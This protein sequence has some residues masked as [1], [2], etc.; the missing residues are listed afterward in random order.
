VSLFI[1]VG[2]DFNIDECNACTAPIDGSD[3]YEAYLFELPCVP[4]CVP[5]EPEGIPTSTPTSSPSSSVSP[6]YCVDQAELI[7]TS[8]TPETI[9]ETTI[10]ITGPNTGTV[11]FDVVQDMVQEGN[12]DEFAVRY[13][14]ENFVEVCAKFTDIEYLH[15]ES[16]TAACVDNITS[17]SLFIYVGDDFNIDECNACAAPI[18]G[19]DDYEAY[20][21]ELPCV[22]VCVPEEPEVIPGES[23]EVIPEDNCPEV[24]VTSPDANNILGANIISVTTQSTGYVEFEVTFDQSDAVLSVQYAS[25]TE[26]SKCINSNDMGIP[27]S[28][29]AVCEDGWTQAVVSLYL[30][31]GVVGGEC[32]FC[33]PPSPDSSIEYSTMT[34]EIPCTPCPAGDVI[35]AAASSTE[36]APSSSPT[37]VNIVN[38]VVADVTTSCT[39]QNVF[40]D[41]SHERDMWC[42]E[43]SLEGVIEVVEQ[44]DNGSVIFSLH[45]SLGRDATFEIEFL[46]LVNESECKTLGSGSVIGTG[47]SHGETLEAKCVDGKAKI[48]LYADNKSRSNS[49]R[50]NGL[51]KCKDVGHNTCHVIYELPCKDGTTV[52]N[53]CQEMGTDRKLL[54]NSPVAL[55]ESEDGPYCLNKDFPCTGDEEN[56]VFVCHYS[57]RGGYQ[58]FCIPEVD[59]DIMRFYSSD[60]C[61]PCEGWNGVS[62]AGQSI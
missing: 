10:Q 23:P 58:T 13:L 48:T 61:G 22:P 44:T 59:S 41:W 16:F 37:T 33:Q 45:N 11:D 32:D 30:G 17:V 6:T 24:S 34:V 49:A 12:L 54:D 14:D 4:V 38:A 27:L 35:S 31:E 9:S 50:P 21:F 18:D 29:T 57:T 26:G 47:Q 7:S 1:Y 3:D 55:E 52:T 8:G 25:A 46:D 20:L 42:Q 40:V 2:D 53:P 56:M 5:E 51:G 19:S 15:T 28:G 62:H 36:T 39:D 60:Y 43:G